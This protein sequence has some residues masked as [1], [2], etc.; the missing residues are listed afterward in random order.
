MPRPRVI[1]KNLNVIGG[2][3]TRIRKERGLS[4]R[5]LTAMFQVEGFEIGETGVAR[6]ERQERVVRDSELVKIS[7]ALKVPVH[8]L[9]GLEES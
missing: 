9:L 3:V 2:T 5:E 1:K 7:R 6:L 4:I 8:V